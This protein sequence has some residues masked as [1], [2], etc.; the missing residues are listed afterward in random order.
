MIVLFSLGARQSPLRISAQNADA[1]F[2]VLVRA[3]N[4]SFTDFS[5]S[6][7][8]TGSHQGT[9]GLSI[10]IAGGVAGFYLDNNY[11]FHGFL[12]TP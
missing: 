8:G 9:G 3:A 4:G 2:S 11:V 1:C 10:N 7:G 5:A 6:G 12:Y